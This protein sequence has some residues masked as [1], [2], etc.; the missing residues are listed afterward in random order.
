MCAI[1]F[2]DIL[3]NFSHFP[4]IIPYH[5]QNDRKE[6]IQMPRML[7]VDD[8]IYLRKLVLTYAQLENF[9]CSEAENSSQALE[10]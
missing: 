4:Y 8:D 10:F 2:L 9:Q 6:V 5:L 3:T 1:N 7:I